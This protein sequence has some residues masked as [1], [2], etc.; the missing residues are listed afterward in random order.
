MP[1]SLLAERY[2]LETVRAHLL[3][4]AHWRR[5]P[6]A[7]DRAAWEKI[8]PA[9]RTALI[10][11]G[12]QRAAEDWEHLRATLTLAFVRHGNRRDYETLHFRRRS[13]LHDLVLAECAEGRGRFLDAIGDNLW[14]TCEETYWG[15]PAHLSIQAAGFGLP[16]TTEPTVDLF[17]AETAALLA[18]TLHLLGE[19]LDA[20]SPLLAPRLRRELEH[21]LLTPCFERDDFWWM[22]W[23]IGRNPINN[24]NPWVNSNW[25][26]T[27]LV[28]ETDPDRRARAVHKIMRSLD[29]FLNHQPADGGC[30]EGPN[31]WDRAAGSLFDC[32]DLLRHAT[33]GAINLFTEP[34]I[35]ELGRFIQRAHMCGDW[36]VNF[37]DASARPTINAD[38]VQRFG[39][40]IRDEQLIGFGRE[41][42]R[43]QAD[44]A[45]A[46]IRSLNRSLAALL[47]PVPPANVATPPPGDVWLPDLQFMVAR[48]PRLVIAAKGGHN[49]ESHNHNDVGSFIACLDGSPLLIDVGVETYTAKTFS[50]QRYK[51]WTMQSQW[52]NLP[53]INGAQQH[54]DRDYTARDTRFSR[55]AQGTVF[56]LDIAGAYPAEAAVKRWTRTLRIE[57]SDTLTLTDDFALSEVREPATW[58]FMCHRRPEI[59]VDG[60][61]RLRSTDSAVATLRHATGTYNAVIDEVNIT[62]PQLHQVWGYFI[63]RLRLCAKDHALAGRHEFSLQPA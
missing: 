23:H 57:P 33:G 1:R 46:Q 62:D 10:Q 8:P 58:H 19:K 53:V 35:A 54:Q 3:D 41:I 38:L 49:E 34:L 4:A 16:D 20:F 25:L 44:H 17:A 63:Y 28:V 60:E 61:V 37:A 36:Y 21:R 40:A 52:H 31:Y 29:V 13:R 50:P 22:G 32:L 42:R 47:E 30:E 15:L 12:E 14:L 45:L 24:W 43:T 39:R 56:T 7:A 9:T 18:W 55:D 6:A 2:D 26:A 11:R 51:L 48:T 5:Y 59:T 27:L